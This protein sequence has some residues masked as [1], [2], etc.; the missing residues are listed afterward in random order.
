MIGKHQS[1]TTVPLRTTLTRTITLYEL[2]MLLGPSNLLY[3]NLSY[4]PE[5]INIYLYSLSLTV[6]SAT[7]CEK[8]F[9][10]Y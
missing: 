3:L 9:V 8:F 6:F 1:P 4:F 5:H 7:M 10:G 2:L